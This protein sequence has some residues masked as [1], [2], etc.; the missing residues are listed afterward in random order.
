M[1]DYEKNASELAE[2]YDIKLIVL[3][4][5]YREYFPDDTKKR[6]V[7]KFGLSSPYYEYI[8]TFGDSIA[9]TNKNHKIG[10]GNKGY[11]QPGFYDIF[12]SVQK[13]EVSRDIDEFISEFCYTD[14]YGIK[15]LINLHKEV[16]QEYK[17]FSSLFR[18]GIIPDDI[19]EIC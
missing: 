18:K 14:E 3:D 12:A 9:N 17:N 16:I 4:C 11:K 7:Y 8:F 19:L 10:I 15:N 2:K 5:T 13:H 6:D 1:T